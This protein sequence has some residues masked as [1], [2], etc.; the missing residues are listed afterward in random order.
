ML[1]ST[2]HHDSQHEDDEDNEDND[3]NEDDEGDEGDEGNEGNED[4]S[5]VADKDF[6]VDD[7][8]ELEIIEFVICDLLFVNH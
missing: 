4:H 7:D 5:E 8:S 1:Y 2:T 3:D 6:I